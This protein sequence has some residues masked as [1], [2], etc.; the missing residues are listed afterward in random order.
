MLALET[1]MVCRKEASIIR[2]TTRNHREKTVKGENGRKN[3]RETG[4]GVNLTTR[5][6]E[7]K[8]L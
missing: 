6:G 2:E 5:Q 7:V 4:K 1:N 3:S 8:T